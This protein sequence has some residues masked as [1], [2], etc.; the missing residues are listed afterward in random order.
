[1]LNILI[2]KPNNAVVVYC[3]FLYIQKYNLSFFS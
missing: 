2:W 1:L 3:Y